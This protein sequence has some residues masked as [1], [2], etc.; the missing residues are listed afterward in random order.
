MRLYSL[1][2]I[3]ITSLLFTAC[4]SSAKIPNSPELKKY[5]LVKENC[6]HIR[7]TPGIF[8]H[9]TV[10]KECHAFLIRLDKA[11]NAEYKLIRF[12][13]KHPNSDLSRESEY[14]MLK[15]DTY[16][17][18][19]KTEVAYDKLTKELNHVSLDA[20][21]HNELSDVDLTLTFAET[22]F[23]KAHYDYYKKQD[24][25]YQED[26]HYILFEKQ[27]SRKL[28]DKGLLYLS[29]GDKRSA[30]KVFRTAASM[31][32][33]QAEYLVG[34]VYEA[35]NVDK[36]ITWHTKALDH[37]EKGSRINLARLHLRKREPKI[38]QQF[39]LDAANDNDAYAQYILYK[40][41]DKTN[42]TKT[43][44]QALTWLLKSANNGFGPAEDAYGH[45]LLKTKKVTDAKVWLEKA[46]AHGMPSATDALGII[47]YNKKEYAKALSC[48]QESKSIKAKVAL[49]KMYEHGLGVNLD[50][51]RAYMLYKE[52]VR[53]GAKQ[54]NKNVKRLSKLSSAKEK[55]HYEAAKR[56]QR[57]LSKKE[58][59]Y[60]G[61][62]PILRNLRTAGMKIRLKGIVSLPLETSQGFIVSSADGKQFY[63]MDTE[64][65][66]KVNQFDYVDIAT[67]ATAHAVII[68]NDDGL[69]TAIYQ[70]HYLTRCH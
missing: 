21:E 19:R 69:T 55:A 1:L 58:N 67:K 31:R 56:K 64:Q 17:Q 4:G 23:T 43:N 16:R 45:Y 46:S 48:L 9:D 63:V 18:H 70:L 33:A 15:K 52:A 29:R 54:Y 38:A 30:L 8:V 36:A 47:Y 41:Y 34:I 40:Q 42:N 25:S 32:N 6:D 65:E 62:D 68:S 39:Y 37:G 60:Y 66:A 51:Y 20:I 28:I 2:L 61:Q 7:L 53:L 22:L 14:I 59:A 35:K 11:N 44:A 27:Y 24:I 10:D 50:Y 3:F 26:T 12:K 57:E 5:A 13:E 49:A